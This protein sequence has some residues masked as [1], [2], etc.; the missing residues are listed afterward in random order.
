VTLFEFWVTLAAMK[1]STWRALAV[2][3]VAALAFAGVAFAANSGSFA[4]VAGDSGT[5]PD[6]TGVAISSDDT[7]MVTIKVTLGN[8]TTFGAGDGVGLGIDAD[9]NP[10]TGTVFY[11]AE[12]ELDLEGTAAKVYRATANG[13]YEEAPLPPSFKA[14]FDSGVVTVTFKPSEIGTAT[15]F[16]VYTVGFDNSTLDSAP[17]IRAVNYQLVN[18]APAPALSPDHRAP[19]DQA[20]K[21]IGTHGKVASLYYFASDGR[22]ETADAI[23]VSKGKKVLKRINFLLEDTN[24]FLPYIA[25]WKVPKKTKGKL[26]FCVTSTDRAGN[27]SNTSCAALT[28]K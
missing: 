2:V 28:I 15:G 4:D 1:G 27:K 24:P 14:S 8:R 23:V 10:D 21:S 13:F 25:R 18:G 3:G 11:G 17:D 26:R 7:G 5:A 12:Y 20:I 16:N 6:V 19:V 9:Q 22:G